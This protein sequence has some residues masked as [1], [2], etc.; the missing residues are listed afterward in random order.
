MQN[1]E[2]TIILDPAL[3]A[4]EAD[5]IFKKYKT[6]YQK[7]GE[8]VFDDCWGRRRL[9]YTVQ[10]KDYGIYYLFFVKLPSDFIVKL[11]KEFKFNDNI[12]KYMVL[13]VSD[14]EIEYKNFESI[15]EAPEQTGDIYM[16]NLQGE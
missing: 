4:D 2:I 14:L 10:K 16:K 12:I 5:T 11:E 1:Y 15:K 8:V 6:L 7:Q 13:S 3:T 9:A